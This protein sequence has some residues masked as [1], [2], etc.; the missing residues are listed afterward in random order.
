MAEKAAVV[1]NEARKEQVSAMI[2]N[3]HFLEEDREVLMNM[4]CPQFSRVQA[5][6]AKPVETVKANNA[7]GD[8]EGLMPPPSR[9]QSTTRVRCQQVSG[10]S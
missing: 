10:A 9:G 1:A 8:F 3:G 5:L 4:A 6:L 2:A 7:P